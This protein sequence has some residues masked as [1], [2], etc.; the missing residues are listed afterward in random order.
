VVE[1][2][3]AQSF[4]DEFDVSFDEADALGSAER[5][6]FET[7]LAQIDSPDWIYQ[8]NGPESGAPILEGL[9]RGPGGLMR[10]AVVLDAQRQRLKQ[11]WITGDFFVNP[12][13][14]VVD[15][16][17][18]LRNTAL[19]DLERNVA[20]F[21]DGYPVEMLMLGRDDFVAV[22]RQAV[23]AQDTGADSAAG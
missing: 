17:A 21:F 1:L 4:A 14:M 18:A 15:L 13:R 7:A 10:A 12:R 23:A 16:E 9:Y 6:R 20:A 22:I 8:H 19:A 3:I 11:V 5:E 2:A